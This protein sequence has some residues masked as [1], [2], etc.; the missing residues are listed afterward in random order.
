MSGIGILRFI[1]EHP[2]IFGA[3]FALNVGMLQQLQRERDLIVIRQH[4]ALEP[5]LA[6]IALHLRRHTQRRLIQPSPHRRKGFALDWNEI[7]GLGIANWPANE[8]SSLAPNLFGAPQ[9][10][11]KRRNSLQRRTFCDV[12]INRAEIRARAFFH[13]RIDSIRLAVP[14]E[15]HQLSHLN[16]TQKFA[17]IFLRERPP[18][19]CLLLH[20]LVPNLVIGRHQIE[21]RRQTEAMT[22][23]LQQS[24]TKTVD[25]S[26]ESAVKR[27]QHIKRN[28]GAQNFGASAL[29]H[30]VRS[31]IG[32]RHYH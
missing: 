26:E 22:V 6:I 17:A 16:M 31:A 21:L 19:L 3:D 30:F 23:R 15:L 5:K 14:T 10:L 32:K 12:S 2:E 18:D 27:A 28:T 1:Q 29:L 24:H 25:G 9:L 20:E 13:G 7:A 11:L 4:S 8:I